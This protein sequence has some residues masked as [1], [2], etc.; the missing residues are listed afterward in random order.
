MVVREL[1]RDWRTGSVRTI[2]QPHYWSANKQRQVTSIQSRMCISHLHR[3]TRYTF[4]W[5]SM[6]SRMLHSIPVLGIWRRYLVQLAQDVSSPGALAQLLFIG[7]DR[8][9]QLLLL[10]LVSE[11]Q[12]L[13]DDVV[14]ELR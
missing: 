8:L 12:R 4:T 3:L 13:L 14:G 10:L 2:S 7:T 5:Y 6:V 1:P 11:L 9:E